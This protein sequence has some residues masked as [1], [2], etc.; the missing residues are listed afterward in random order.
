MNELRDFGT[1][2]L[3]DPGTSELR[4]AV[5]LDRDG[6]MIEEAGYLSSLDAVKWYPGTKDSIRLL[7]RAGFL[8]CVITNQGGIGLGLFDEGFVQRVHASMEAELAASGAG[9]DGWYY[10]PHHPNATIPGLKSPCAC[11]K[12]GRAM[13]DAACR[14][15]GIDLS[16]SWVIGDRDV[17]VRMAAA[18]GARGILVT[19]GHGAR[20]LAQL[21]RALP[22]GTLVARDLTEAVAEVLTR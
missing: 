1:S 11:R 9:I 3:R 21:G 7:N 15:H 20:D 5:F 16:R 22:D 2:G 8:V 19:T 17:D 14:D 4:P 18:V 6:T 10:C 13:I 12:P